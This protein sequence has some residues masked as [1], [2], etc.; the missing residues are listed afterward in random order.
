[1]LRRDL[2]RA[3]MSTP[4]TVWLRPWMPR[5]FTGEAIQAPNAAAIYRSVFGWPEGLRSEDRELLRNA[6]TIA[7][8]HPRIRAWLKQARPV[9]TSMRE[10]A[11]IA[12]CDWELETVR[13]EDLCK[14]H[15]GV[16]NIDLIRL[17]CLSVRHNAGL[18]RGRDALDDVFAGLTLAHRI[19]TGGVNVSR[20]LECGGEVAAFQTLGR[21]LPDLDRVTL[22][23][24]SRRLDRLPPPEPAS[25]TIG[26]ESRFILGSLRARLMMIGPVIRDEDWS[27]LGLDAEEAVTLRRLTHSD[28]AALLAHLDTNGPAFAELARRLDLPRP[29]CRAALD[30]FARAERADHPL[31]VMIVENVWGIRHVVDRMR[32]L[33]AMVRASI[34]L[35]RDGEPAFRAVADPFGDGPFGLERSVKGYRIRS[36]LSDE[37]KPDVTLLIGDPT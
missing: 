13:V 25:A 3:L 20:I 7:I 10:A 14:G 4:L 15:L 24:L 31:V 35:V 16:F 9:L 11:K 17:T 27:E 12:H 30:E 19:G 5:A 18:R 1:M 6:A 26:P 28:R 34:A 23:D 2:L 32:A 36:A 22:D 29:G 21:I 8:D 33:R 37:G